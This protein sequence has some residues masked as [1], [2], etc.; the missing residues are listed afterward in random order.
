MVGTKG[1]MFFFLPKC[2]LGSSLALSTSGWTYHA[3]KKSMNWSQARQWCQSTYTDMVVLQN[4]RENDYLVS[5]LRNKSKSPYYWIGVTKNHRNEPWTWIGNNSTWVGEHS[6]AA[7]EP[8]NNHIT[9]FCVEIYCNDTSCERGRCQET[10]NNV[11][12]LSQCNDTSCERGRCQETINNVTCLS[13]QCPALPRPDNG[14]LSCFGGK[15]T[16]NSTCRYGCNLGFLILGLP[17]VTCEVTGLQAGP[18][19]FSWERGAVSPLL[20][21]LLLDETPKNLI[22]VSSSFDLILDL[23]SGGGAH[24]WSYAFSISPNRR[25]QEAR[26][27]CQQHFTDMVPIRNQEESDFI[28]NFLPYNAKYYWIGIGKREGEWVW[29]KTDEKVPEDAQNWA[30]EEPDNI[31]TQD[32]VEIYIKRDKDT[33]KWNNENCRKRKGTDF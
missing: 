4:Q 6:W 19:G 1:M 11:T 26:Q 3:H 5:T 18:A 23:S 13:V 25:W 2:I 30:P 33:A 12:C 9:E 14:Y 16:F 22:F 28:N 27:W 15:L 8:N 10:I 21:L 20:P 31:A 7:N 17:E 29:K 32:C 24:A